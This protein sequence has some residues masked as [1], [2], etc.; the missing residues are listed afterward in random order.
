MEK[1]LNKKGNKKGKTPTT[2]GA[3]AIPPPK[4][5][6]P[7]V[8]ARTRRAGKNKAA[9][10]EADPPAAGVAAEDAAKAE[11]AAKAGKEAET[12]VADAA[13]LKAEALAAEDKAKAALAAAAAA[14]AA[15]AGKKAP[16]PKNLKKKKEGDGSDADEGDD[17]DGGVT[18][19]DPPGAPSDSLVTF[20]AAPTM[21]AVH[22]NAA[23]EP[24]VKVLKPN[25]L[26]FPGYFRLYPGQL[27]E[28]PLGS[29]G[30]TSLQRV[31][32]NA[33][34]LL[35][36]LSSGPGLVCKFI[37]V[38]TLQVISTLDPSFHTGW[39]SEATAENVYTLEKSDETG[40]MPLTFVDTILTYL[41]EGAEAVEATH[42]YVGRYPGLLQR[43]TE[44][45][46]LALL[47][48][49]Q[50]L[51]SQMMRAPELKAAFVMAH[52]DGLLGSGLLCVLSKTTG[53]LLFVQHM[54]EQL[55]LHRLTSVA[56]PAKRAFAG[57]GAG[58]GGSGRKKAKHDDEGAD[59]AT[60]APPTPTN[61]YKGVDFG[62]KLPFFLLNP[63]YEF[64]GGECPVHGPRNHTG[65]CKLLKI[66]TAKAAYMARLAQ[67][68]V[69]RIPGVG[70]SYKKISRE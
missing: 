58:G 29:P 48:L 44:L 61:S 4:D 9:E 47:G 30:A 22:K 31:K 3:A 21:I 49:Q 7:A 52:I 39:T 27:P 25:S 26:F 13:R 24:L 5:K 38:A 35:T 45:V 41:D 2:K 69:T 10:T 14:A 68:G 19:L 60:R 42:R 1:A 17:G 32:A 63:A 56:Q 18:I 8:A 28:V 70:Q 66:P 65:E 16:L 55:L 34:I 46:K 59:E 62:G 43:A 54:F 37:V 15:I 6:E 50:A 53:S 20:A 64:K 33:P 51:V 23:T 57:G 36:R 40:V 12:A 11:A 67:L